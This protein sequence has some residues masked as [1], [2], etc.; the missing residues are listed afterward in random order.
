MEEKSAWTYLGVG[1]L[2]WLNIAPKSLGYGALDATVQGRA[3]TRS[4]EINRIGQTGVI[5]AIDDAVQAGRFPRNSN[6]AIS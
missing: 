3:S 5:L 4:P 6:P 1:A 2:S